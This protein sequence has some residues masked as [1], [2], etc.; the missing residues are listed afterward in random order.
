[1]LCLASLVGDVNISDDIVEL[2]TGVLGFC[3]VVVAVAL[4]QQHGHHDF[5]TAVFMGIAL[6]F[7]R[8]II[9]G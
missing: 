5:E 7:Y 3:P 1:M 6:G 4:G 8:I 2:W 9:V